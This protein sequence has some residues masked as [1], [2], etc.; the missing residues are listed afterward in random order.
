MWTDLAYK[1]GS[2]TVTV[3]AY[4]PAYFALVRALPELAPWLAVGDA[5]VIAGG[6]VSIRIEAA[7]LTEWRGDSL[8]A[9]VRDFRAR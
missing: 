7:G 3:A 9:T 4:S 8:T 1:P 5:V 6:R 2:S